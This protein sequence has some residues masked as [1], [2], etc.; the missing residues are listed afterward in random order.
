MANLRLSFD[1]E[2]AGRQFERSMRNKGNRVHKAIVA[3]AKEAREESLRR[4]RAD[5]AS[6][7]RFGP[8]WTR[9]L[10]ATVDEGKN[11]INM[12]VTHDLPIFWTFQQATNQKR[13]IIKG[14]PLLW[15][16]LSFAKDAQGVRARDYPGGLFRVDR[17]SGGAPL[18]LSIRDRKPKYFGKPFVVIPKKFHVIEI[19]REVAGKLGELYK[20]HF[21]NGR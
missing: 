5:I 7:G 20:R 19:I 9:G 10:K 4:G 16:P 12:N 11:E 2:T 1:G 21:K 18:L 14:K 6:A 3:A 8:R 13:L 17:K 15:I